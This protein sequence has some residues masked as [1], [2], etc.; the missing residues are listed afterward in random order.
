MI[1]SA[2]DIVA[3][4]LWA[5][6][7]RALWAIME[8]ADRKNDLE[9]VEK[10]LG[11]PLEN[12]RRVTMRDGVAIIPVTGPIFRY[13]NLFTSLS[14]A[15][16]G[17]VLAK[18]L[19]T[20]LEDPAVE[21]ILFSVDS[22]GGQANGINELADMIFE[23]RAAN[24]KPMAAYVS[25]QCCSAAYW[26]ASAVGEIVVDETAQL[27]SIGVVLGLRDT[28]E[29]DKMMGIE[30]I[31]IVSSN[32]PDKRIDPKTAKGRAKL[33]AMADALARV[34]TEKVA[35]NRGVTI[36]IVN[37]EFGAGGILTGADAVAAGLADR[38]GNFETTLAN[39]AVLAPAATQVEE[40]ISTGASTMPSNPETPTPAP[41]ADTPP[42][43]ITDAD[44]ERFRLEGAQAERDRLAGL[45]ENC[46]PGFENLR[47]ECRADGKST[48]LDLAA[49][50]IAVQKKQGSNALE[51]ASRAEKDLTDLPPAKPSITG[52]D[53]VPAPDPDDTEA[54]DAACQRKWDSDAGLRSEFA[55]RK[56]EYFAYERAEAKGLIRRPIEKAA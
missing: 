45:D 37:D 23:A 2:F 24:T 20:A 49:K 12:T 36:D 56:A 38:I 27:G 11:R 16:S 55:G 28:S 26:I 6:E 7:E 35:R 4:T 42:A 17:E 39:I 31:E 8:I 43:V 40:P 33:L 3:S 14:G 30:T 41:A 21:A 54:F 47:D 53:P 1:R 48:G 51:A 50:I 32:A 25:G 5:I 29:R 19:T 44:R 9:A 13:A 10:R 52:D 15:T 22:P 34:F 46:L 18:D